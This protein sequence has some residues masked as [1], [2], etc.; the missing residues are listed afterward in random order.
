MLFITVSS[1]QERFS[2]EIDPSQIEWDKGQYTQV[3]VNIYTKGTDGSMTNIGSPPPFMPKN[4]GKYL[5]GFLFDTGKTPMYFYKV[6][7]WIK[8]QPQPKEIKETQVQ[9]Q[10]VL[11]LPGKPPEK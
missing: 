8:D 1:T 6:Q 7:Y 10:G 9:G 5:Y 3:V 11:T 2:V 4:V